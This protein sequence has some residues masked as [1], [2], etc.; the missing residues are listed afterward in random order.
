[1][2]YLDAEDHYVGIGTDDY[3]VNYDK[4]T[5]AT[6]TFQN[7]EKILYY[8]GED[9]HN[10]FVFAETPPEHQ[11]SFG[12]PETFTVTWKDDDGSVLDTESYYYDDIPSYK[13]TTPSAA[14]K[15]FIGWT[16]A[17]T[18]VTE[19]AVY[20]ANYRLTKFFTGYSLVLEG[21]IGIYFFIDVTAAGITPDDIR[22]GNDSIAFS[23]S[24]NTTPAPYTNLSA[25][26]IVLNKDNYS[27]RFDSSS[28]LFKI[29]CDVAA[30]EMTCIV[31]ADAVVTDTS[32]GGTVY[33]DDDDYAVYNYGMTIVNAPE[34]YGTKLV[35]LATAMLDY[36]A[37]AQAVFNI[38]TGVY[39]NKDLTGY[40]MENV[41]AD[42]VEAAIKTANA[43]SLASDMREN[44]DSFGLKY[45]GSTIVYLT[46]TTLRHY[47]T[48]T[49][50]SAYDSAKN[51]TTFTLNETKLPYV[52]FEQTNIA[53]KDLD[54]L[55]AFT[56][57]GQTYNFSVLDYSK[58]VLNS[59]RADAN[60]KNLAMATYWYNQKANSYFTNS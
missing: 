36:G 9:D 39:A 15:V 53:A 47:F 23:F 43:D 37:K 44:T 57:N 59:S 30:A 46:R 29:R 19:D 27:E 12:T 5:A 7:S 1:M 22:D 52:I 4:A 48:I 3:G 25:N 28:G 40:S 45:Y 2:D 50:Q 6:Y 38:N 42:T 21:N 35:D 20:T 18:A 54:T 17:I 24:W 32:S 58:S 13:G 33:T 26:N 51:G 60:N 56:I 16:P 41:T 49:D 14:G 8:H 11:I 34:K 55:Q 31:H 10:A